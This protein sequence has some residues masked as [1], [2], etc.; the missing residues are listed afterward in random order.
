MVSIPLPDMIISS[1]QL[2]NIESKSMK[3][4]LF[5]T[6]DTTAGLKQVIGFIVVKQKFTLQEL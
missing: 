5:L 3:K 6:Y 1:I 4:F 2:L